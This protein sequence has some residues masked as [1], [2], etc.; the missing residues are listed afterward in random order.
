MVSRQEWDE[1]YAEVEVE[2]QKLREASMEGGPFMIFYRP[3][4]QSHWYLHG[5]EASLYDIVNLN[6]QL[7]FLPDDDLEIAVVASKTMEVVAHGENSFWPCCQSYMHSIDE[8]KGWNTTHPIF[9]TMLYTGEEEV[10]KRIT[11]LFQAQ[12]EEIAIALASNPPAA[13]SKPKGRL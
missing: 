3:A 11:G 4:I 9:G 7:A 1:L 2:I 10:V 8:G 12:Q 13:Q 6:K 5:T